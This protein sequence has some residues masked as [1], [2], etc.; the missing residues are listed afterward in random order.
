[1]EDFRLLA[2]CP[3]AFQPGARRYDM[4]ERSNFALMPVAKAAL[5]QLLAWGPENTARTLGVMTARIAAEAAERFGAGAAPDALRSPHYL[6]LRMPGGLP[7]GFAQ[8][9][10]ARN[11]HLS[12]RGDRVR[13]T[14][15]LYNDEEDIQRLFEA[16]ER[17][18]RRRA[19]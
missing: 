3:D 16:M 2:E 8:D 14:P 18:L 17:S 6:G 7:E 4:G 15:H 1:M 13:V 12:L 19:V 11:V 9:L 5:E 10:A